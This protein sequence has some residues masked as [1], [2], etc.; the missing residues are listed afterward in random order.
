[1][2]HRSFPADEVVLFPVTEVGYETIFFLINICK[3]L[4]GL[5]SLNIFY[6]EKIKEEVINIGK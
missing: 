5:N 6:G 1:M 2:I 4:C 3:F